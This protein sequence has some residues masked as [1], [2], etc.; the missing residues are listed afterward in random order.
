MHCILDFCFGYMRLMDS[1]IATIFI[2]ETR[3]LEHVEFAPVDAARAT[4]VVYDGGAGDTHARHHGVPV[5][6]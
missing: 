5:G 1:S 4:A 3:S 6:S 2:T